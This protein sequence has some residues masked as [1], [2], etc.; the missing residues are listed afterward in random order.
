[1]Q[2]PSGDQRITLPSSRVC[3][4]GL[5][6][7]TPPTPLGAYVESSDVGNLLFL[8]GILP[9]VNGK[10]VISSRLGDNL[11]GAGGNDG[12]I[13]RTRA[14]SGWSLKLVRSDL[15]TSRPRSVDIWSTKLAH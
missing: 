12:A 4:L 6:L 14:R 8:S 2:A 7:P 9:I 1:M 13:Y 3:E 5:V 11:S 15:W 10:L